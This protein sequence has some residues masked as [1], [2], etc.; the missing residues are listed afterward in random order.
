M[1]GRREGSKE[2]FSFLGDQR[3]AVSTSAFLKDLI[4]IPA[5]CHERFRSLLSFSKDVKRRKTK[6]LRFFHFLKAECHEI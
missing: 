2:E 1:T 4:N 6:E 5:M 3:D